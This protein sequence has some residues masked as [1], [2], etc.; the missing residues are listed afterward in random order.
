MP[1][2]AA[3]SAE[4]LD[5]PTPR[6]PK[7]RK[8]KL[9]L[10][11]LMCVGGTMVLLQTP[12]AG[13]LVRPILE[14]QTGMD[15]QTGAIRVTPWGDVTIRDAVFRA[16]GIPG[17]PGRV[18][19]VDRIRA[20][21]D[22]SGT[23]RGS[24][25]LATLRLDGPELVLSQDI[26]SGV[27]NASAFKLF[28]GGGGGATPAVT[29]GRGTIEL[30][31][32]R[33]E[34]YTEL[35]RW[36]VTGDVGK[37]DAD[38][39]AAVSFAAIPA[40]ASMGG[41]P[42]GSLALGGTV[43]PG[44]VDITLEGLELADWP[45]SIVPTRVR[46]LYARLDLRGQL[47]PTR[48]R[49]DE[50]GR[51]IVSM[52]LDGVDLNLPFD[53]SYAIEGSG[54]L[55]RMRST[56]G[57]V[58][59][60]TAGLRCELSGL[61]DEL[62]YDVTLDYRGLGADAPFDARLR[63]AFRLDDSFRPRRFLPPKAIEKLDMFIS[64]AGDVGATVN[65]ARASA[66]GEITI[67]GEARISNGSAR[68][69]K[70]PYPFSNISGS[71]AFTRDDLLIRDIT[72]D[73]PTG[74]KMFAE[75]EFDGLSDDSEVELR[76]RIAGLPLDD[77]LL[78]SLSSGR[79]ELVEAL[80]SEKQ[81]DLLLADGLVRPPGGSGD[82]PEFA[83]G[84]D[85][86]VSLVLRRDPARPSDDRW[87]KDATVRIEHAGLVP[88]HFPLPITASGIEITISGDEIALTGGRYDGLTGGRAYVS[89]TLDPN[90]GSPGRDPLP[91]VRI[92]AEDIP[93]DARLL[94][95]IPGYRSGDADAGESGGLGQVTLR[96]ILD[97]LRVA[98][99][100]ACEA[101]IG[102]RSDGGLGYDIE[103]NMFGASARPVAWAAGEAVV[104]RDAL[105]LE[106]LDGTIY[107]TEQL[108][109]VDLG[110]ELTAPGTPFVPSPIRLL[111][112]L[113][114][115][116]KRGGLGQVERE[117]GLLPIQSGPPLPGPVLYADARAEGLDLA[118]P[119]E[120]AVAVVSPDL[121]TRLAELRAQRQPD[122]VVSL[123][124]E[125]EG[126]VGGHTETVLGIDRVDSFVFTHE[127]ARHR[128][129]PSRGGAELTLGVR[130]EVR[131]R[132][133]ATPI[134]SNGVDAGRLTLD[135]AMPLTRRG[136]LGN[137]G[138]DQMLHARL[139]GGHLESAL[140]RQVVLGAAG[141]TVAQWLLDKSVTGAFDVDLRLRANPAA[142][143]RG[144]GLLYG[145]PSLLATGTLQPR[146]LGL[147]LPEGRVAFDEI[148]GVVTFEG[149]GGRI[150]GLRAVSSDVSLEADGVWGFRPGAGG[151]VDLGLTVT[152]G[153]YGEAVRS[154]L[155]SVVLDTLE[156]F[157][158]ESVGP[159]SAEGMVISGQGLGTED[160]RLSV[161]G[162]VGVTDAS[163]VIGVPI[164][165]MSGVVTF[166][167][168]VT[169][170]GAVYSIGVDAERLRAG[171]LRVED[172]QATVISDPERPGVVLVPE[173]TGRVHGGRIAG[174]AQS[175][176]F[177]GG[178][179]YWVDMH[180]SDVRAAPVFDD[181]LLP[182]GGLEG[183][184]LPGEEGVRS[185]WSVSDDYTRGLLDT[186]IA[187]SGVV[188]QPERTTGRGMV[189]VAG[190]A[191]IALPGL[192]NLIEF[193]NLNAP[194][195]A[196]LDLAEAVFYVDG[197]SLA[198]ER[199]SASSRRVEILG[200][201]TMD[202]TTRA[203]DLRFRS[204]SVNPVPVLSGLFE[205]L[206][207]ELITTRISGRPGALRYAAES[208]GG[209]RRLVR[210]LLGEPETEQERL[211][212][213][214]E[215]ASREENNRAAVGEARVV[216]P[217]ASPAAWADGE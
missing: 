12:A 166:A 25:G 80:F 67:G 212:Q 157:A 91:V 214:V 192:I 37:P 162:R 126:V 173:I 96:S 64:P 81:H 71:V 161:E 136:T 72:G 18:L 181:L 120:H 29:I 106:D 180:A 5:Q 151:S 209:T 58:S 73:G 66:G 207:D 3:E 77:V 153:A 49:V 99:T 105:V 206:R 23:L 145:V 132:S 55:L 103:A 191:V 16:P 205:S 70:L 85:T 59:F 155:P 149:M 47:L 94:A 43:G 134:V 100:V 121:A 7:R 118:M 184:P 33:G 42:S 213:A 19:T 129:G 164:T 139:A 175:H 101:Y 53:A 125:L 146:T 46:D 68:Y 196:T 208:F 15:V 22:W 60:G 6:K 187:L 52:R 36:S 188:G 109:V 211:L 119:I 117:G 93:V 197:T 144:T 199:L 78:D 17:R 148:G 150:D 90:S 147:D 193:S 104:G 142:P 112:Q 98:G 133:F 28:S 124:A 79:R 107:V 87:T 156:L 9:L 169:R 204:R 30:G 50:D 123:R 190:G 32:H 20:G 69:A 11:L 138:G 86:S 174:S 111:T 26:D 75:G 163:A 97:N 179:R 8:R 62:V 158:V 189:R 130:P 4:L 178:R 38:G 201:G 48:F 152:S 1:T 35:R 76:L 82:A 45:A 198:F 165:Q 56:R 215:E 131:F 116:E 24:P 160:S 14:S 202:W 168:E 194:F 44:G 135:G 128:V 167:S 114:P 195:G 2:E 122:G 34:D 110:G 27:L 63:T 186:D 183:P 143:V 92:D 217:S 39:V 176:P 203:I 21:I 84:G 31:E 95:A 177:E 216:R 115:P 40:E 182:A 51:V 89:A 83:F 10:G 74:A 41:S 172:A 140:T 102:P 65:V 210:A 159:I 57:T 61:I 127:G 170:E 108:I 137:R 13:L 141:S 88:K 171:N 200:Y 113:T 185:A 154:L 54:E